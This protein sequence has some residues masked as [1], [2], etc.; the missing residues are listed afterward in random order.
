MGPGK[1]RGYPYLVC[2]KKEVEMYRKKGNVAKLYYLIH[3][4][5]SCIMNEGIKLCKY[6]LHV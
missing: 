4:N 6:L 3:Q 2:K 5:L 1:T